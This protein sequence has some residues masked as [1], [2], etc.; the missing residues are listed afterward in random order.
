MESDFV[1]AGKKMAIVFCASIIIVVG[2]CFIFGKY[3]FFS[4]MM[5]GTWITVDGNILDN[6]SIFVE[7]FAVN[8]PDKSDRVHM[9][10]RFLTGE[11]YLYSKSD[12]GD[13]NLS[14]GVEHIGWYASVA[15]CFDVRDDSIKLFR[16]AVD[17]DHE[18]VL[19]QWKHD[20]ERYFVAANDP[21]M[22][23]SDIIEH[24]RLFVEANMF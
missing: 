22:T 11:P 18:C 4:W 1:Q 12:T 17:T 2:V 5:E 24:F 7:G 13:L 9:Q 16:Y 3:C 14:R 19:F 20:P 23:P 8:D 15:S 10:F 6:Q 21:T